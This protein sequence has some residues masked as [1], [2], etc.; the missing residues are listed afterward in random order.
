MP[1]DDDLDLIQLRAIAEEAT[2]EALA[3]VSI[4]AGRQTIT[5]KFGEIVAETWVYPRQDIADRFHAAF[6]P[7]TVLALLDRLDW[8]EQECGT[9]EENVELLTERLEAAEAA[10]G[11]VRA[12][13][14]EP[15]MS[16]WARRY[17]SGRHDSHQ[18]MMAVTLEDYRDRALSALDGSET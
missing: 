8:I 14:H 2:P 5:T 10:L 12:F 9:A 13:L 7:P 3:G 17:W 15:V 1:N 11:R 16:D 4:R 6:E 18:P